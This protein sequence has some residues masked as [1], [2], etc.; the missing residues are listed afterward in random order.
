M[1]TEHRSG[2]VFVASQMEEFEMDK[3]WPTLMNLIK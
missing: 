1:I 3:R 2:I